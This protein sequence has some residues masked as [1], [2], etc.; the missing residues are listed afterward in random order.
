MCES[1]MNSDPDEARNPEVLYHLALAH[2]NLK[3]YD[4]AA[5]CLHRV[6][7]GD[8]LPEARAVS[9]GYLGKVSRR[10]GEEEAARRYFQQALEV[11]GVKPEIVAE[12]RKFAQE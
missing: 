9:L 12:I 7:E 6:L 5:E 11:P 8:I 1:L 4:S 2:F 10:K 3:H